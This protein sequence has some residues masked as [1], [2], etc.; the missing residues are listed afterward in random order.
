MRDV[1][2]KLKNIIANTSLYRMLT[3]R[4]LDLITGKTSPMR[5]GSNMNIVNQGDPADG[6]YWVVYGQVNIAVHSKQGSAK[7]L[8]ILGAGKCFGLGEMVLDQPHQACVKTTANS[9]LLHTERDA[10]LTVAEENFDFAREV[11]TCLGRQ[12]YGLVRDIGNYS[13][14]AHQRLADYLLRQGDQVPNCEIELVANKGII[15]SRLSLTPETLSR[16]FRDFT[17]DGMIKVNGRR[18]TVL[19]WPKV[20]ALLA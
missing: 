3:P 13:L 16:V 11:M 15:A 20:S 7:M 17:A 19:D 2:P 12:F 1:A 6:T 5:V 18:I 9:M 4:Q 14:S 10:I 8:A